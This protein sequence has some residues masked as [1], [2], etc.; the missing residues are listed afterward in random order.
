MT[1]DSGPPR[2]A[3]S[4]P[5]P[6]RAPPRRARWPLAVGL[7]LLAPLCAEYV[8]GYDTST[9]DPL[10]LAGGL[11]ILAPLYGAPALLIR[12]TARRLGVRWPGI[13]ALAAAFG[14]VQAGVV[15]Q[16]LFSTSYRDIEYWDDML[17]PTLIEPL[18]LSANNAVAF[19]VGHAVWSYGVPIALVESLHPAASRRPWLRAPGLAVTALLYLG[20]AALI[21]SDHLHNEADHASAAQVTGSLVAVA[22]L[23]ALAFTIGRRRPPS[24]DAA[25]PGPFVIG[26]LGLAAA[27]AFNL[28]PPTWPGVAAAL[29]VSAVG[30]ASVAHL[31]RSGRWGGRHVAA[32]ATGALLARAAIGFLAVPLGDVAPLAK[33]AHNTAFLAGAVLLGAWAAWRNRPSAGAGAARAEPLDDDPV[34]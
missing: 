2:S 16:S 8:T 23:A 4:T 1:S 34:R 13:L 5:S 14:V 9:G 30:A 31:S 26:T 7:L 32:L 33:Y 19:V 6:H 25:V 21:L 24:R 18:G 3:R 22:L 20:A 17:L 12:E 29:A 15:D 28:V 11:L 10:A 27:L